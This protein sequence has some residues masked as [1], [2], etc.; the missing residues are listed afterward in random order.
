MDTITLEDMANLLVNV[1]LDEGCDY[2][3][4]TMQMVLEGLW[5]GDGGGGYVCPAVICIVELLKAKMTDDEFASL[6]QLV[7]E[8]MTDEET[9]FDH[10]E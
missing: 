4:E 7:L 6:R 3:P 8:G 9:V 1:G 2:D 5:A 10:S